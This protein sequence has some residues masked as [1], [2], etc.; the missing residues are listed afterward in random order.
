MYEV[1]IEKHKFGFRCYKTSF[2]LNKKLHLLMIIHEK[3]NILSLE[4]TLHSNLKKCYFA[5]SI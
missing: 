1:V 4:K 2:C 3:K 5:P